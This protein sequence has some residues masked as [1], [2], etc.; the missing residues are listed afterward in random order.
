V[1]S[2]L[3]SGLPGSPAFLFL[4]EALAAALAAFLASLS[5]F[6]SSTT[7]VGLSGFA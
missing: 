5:A 6:T 2:I 4:A 7:A 3:A 1:V